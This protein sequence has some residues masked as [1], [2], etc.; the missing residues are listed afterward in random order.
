MTEQHDWLDSFFEGSVK[1]K[2]IAY[3]SITQEMCR[4][5]VA[6]DPKTLADVPAHLL[7]ESMIM[8]ALRLDPCAIEFVPYERFKQQYRE[9]A[10]WV[11]RQTPEAV[12]YFHAA[13][14][15]QYGE[16]L[17]CEEPVCMLNMTP[18]QR[19]YGVIESALELDESL[20]ADCPPAEIKTKNLIPVLARLEN[21]FYMMP[22]VKTLSELLL[23]RPELAPFPKPPLSEVLNGI[24]GIDKELSLDAQKDAVF[25]LAYLGHFDVAEV[26]AHTSNGEVFQ[27][28]MRVFQPEDFKQYCLNHE[29]TR[30]YV[31]EADLGL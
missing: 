3:C 7:D 16:M 11:I 25:H 29:R 18:A 31:L 23:E 28:A 2:D 14:V 19:T 30:D 20:L 24:Q 26:A 13:F 27:L 22:H 1:L 4:A 21:W 17:A 15:E 8:E 9:W 10:V 12:V 5:S 6:Y